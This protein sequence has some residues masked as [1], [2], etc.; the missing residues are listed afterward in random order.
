MEQFKLDLLEE[1][2]KAR[3]KYGNVG[4]L[5]LDNGLS[6]IAQDHANFLAKKDAGL[7]SSGHEELG[8]NLFQY[9]GS[10]HKICPARKIVETFLEEAKYYDFDRNDLDESGQQ[11]VSHFTQVF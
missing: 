11:R 8:E 3:T 6:L 7:F 4:P 1:H 10:E 9:F 5:R 2:N